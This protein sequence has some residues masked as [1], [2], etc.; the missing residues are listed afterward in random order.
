[1]PHVLVEFLRV[2]KELHLTPSSHRAQ[3]EQVWS[4]LNAEA[5]LDS[6]RDIDFELSRADLIGYVLIDDL[7][8]FCDAGIPVSV[9]EVADGQ[10]YQGSVGVHAHPRL[11]PESR[12]LYG[13]VVD[14]LVAHGFFPHT[15]AVRRRL[16]GRTGGSMFEGG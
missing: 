6:L 4:A 16:I 13:P 7:A 10:R 8:G 3:I 5:P 15:E 2:V 14:Y 12:N 9:E 11:S 1:M